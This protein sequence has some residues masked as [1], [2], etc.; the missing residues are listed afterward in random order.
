MAKLLLVTVMAEK[1]AA[2]IGIIV[3]IWKPDE[4]VLLTSADRTCI[5]FNYDKF[6]CTQSMFERMKSA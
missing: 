6:C 3:S 4:E 2:H 5:Q 1:H